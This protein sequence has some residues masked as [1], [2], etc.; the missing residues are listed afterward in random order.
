MI[1][2]L[3]GEGISYGWIGA[4][5]LYGRNYEFRDALHKIGKKYVVDIQ[6]DHCIYL[7]RPHI[8]IPKSKTGRGRK[9]FTM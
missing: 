4:D 5:A 1:K 3:D 6:R 9:I 8:Y 2:E 7:E